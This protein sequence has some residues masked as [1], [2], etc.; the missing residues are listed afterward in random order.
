MQKHMAHIV[1][2]EFEV[3][4]VRMFKRECSVE[5]TQFKR[6]VI[7]VLRKGLRYVA[8]K[9]AMMLCPDEVEK[10]DHGKPFY[11]PIVY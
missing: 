10:E 1:A 2:D 4:I 9:R 8:V 7:Q 6:S 5:V 3:Q 11:E